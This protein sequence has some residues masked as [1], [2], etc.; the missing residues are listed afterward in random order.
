MSINKIAEFFKIK[1]IGEGHKIK[2]E[3]SLKGFFIKRGALTWPSK[4][5]L[6]FIGIGSTMGC[7]IW[8]NIN[9][10]FSKLISMVLTSL[11]LLI[12]GSLVLII[13]KVLE[14]LF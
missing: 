7:F 4:I 3:K 9:A 12:G 8:L 14:D 13:N 5:L 6:G 1:S 10:E 11:W 2:E